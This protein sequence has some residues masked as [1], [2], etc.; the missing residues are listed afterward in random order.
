MLQ[1]CSTAAHLNE[2]TDVPA[3]GTYTDIALTCDIAKA[4]VAGKWPEWPV[5]PCVPDWFAAL[6]R[7]VEHQTPVRHSGQVGQIQR[8]L[9]RC[10]SASCRT[11]EAQ[12]NSSA[13]TLYDD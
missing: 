3:L 1:S 9:E 8:R 4:V 5:E 11:C 7:R 10:R 2:A 12:G 13:H 6:V